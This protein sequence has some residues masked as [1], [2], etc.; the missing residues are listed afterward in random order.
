MNKLW[1]KM[2]R[3]TK[4]E[5]MTER[6]TSAERS[7][8]KALIASASDTMGT[9][10]TSAVTSHHV[11]S[12]ESNPRTLTRVIEISITARNKMFRPTAHLPDRVLGLF[13]RFNTILQLSNPLEATALAVLLS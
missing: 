8:L 7:V 2:N 3:I 10:N 11:S 5:K 9:M 4:A 13:Q 1:V 12:K 6:I